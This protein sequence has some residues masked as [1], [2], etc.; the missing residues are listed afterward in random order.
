MGNWNMSGT[1]PDLL[2]DSATVVSLRPGP[3][4][5]TSSTQ[6][7]QETQEVYNYVQNPTRDNIRIV[8]FWADG[9]GT[10]TPPGHWN[11][12]AAQVSIERSFDLE[13]V[14]WVH[15]IVWASQ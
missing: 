1:K 9:V 6:M 12:I 8:Q 2:I 14:A 7:Q 3:P 4:P 15:R 5:S 10:Y 11:T 13:Q